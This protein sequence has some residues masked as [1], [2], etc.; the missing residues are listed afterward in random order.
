MRLG[1]GS[2]LGAVP[3]APA[4]QQHLGP[5]GGGVGAVDGRGQPVVELVGSRE[6][7][8]RVVPLRLAEDVH[9]MPT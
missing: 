7:V 9:T 2:G 1:E 6:R 8:L 4:A 3:V 5:V